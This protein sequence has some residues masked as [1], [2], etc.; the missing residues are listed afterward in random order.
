M[1]SDAAAMS[2]E[3]AWWLRTLAVFQSPSSTFAALRDDSERQADA[4]QEPILA[5]TWLAGIAGVLTFGST[6][7]TLLDFQPSGEFFRPTQLGALEAAVFVF[8]AGGLYGLASYWLGGGA[9]HLGAR[10]AGGVTSYRQARHVVAFA[11]VPAALSLL[12]WPVRLAIYG[13]DN[14][15]SGG[16]DGGADGFAFAGIQWAFFLWAL[17]LLLVGLRVVHGWSLLRSLGA[18]VLAMLALGAVALLFSLG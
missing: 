1:S 17:G 11:L 14:F 3:R 16:A 18:M 9:L 12:V 15:R 5:V 4:R 7:G 8:L 13:E 2:P 10:A 6:T